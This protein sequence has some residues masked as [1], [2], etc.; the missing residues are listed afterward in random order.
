MAR[1]CT[2]VGGGAV[3]GRIR[4]PRFQNP[5]G[6]HLPRSR[7]RRQGH[8]TL[9][10]AQIVVTRSAHWNRARRDGAGMT[11]RKASEVPLH[12]NAVDI[13]ER[14]LAER[15]DKVALY[16]PERAMTFRQV[17]HEANR[18]GN[19]LKKLGIRLG[20]FVG[21]LSPDRPQGGTSFFCPFKI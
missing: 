8:R 16:S 6:V 5:A 19:A 17:S 15:A 18:V 12:Y 7:L 2:R 20:G 13:L 1:R 11:M 14:N 10:V 4:D 9:S 3:V 21:I